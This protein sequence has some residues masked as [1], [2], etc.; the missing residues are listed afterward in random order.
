MRGRK[1][2]A[3]LSLPFFVAVRVDQEFHGCCDPSVI[4]DIIDIVHSDWGTVFD[5]AVI[6]N[7]KLTNENL[8]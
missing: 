7:E 5:V 3:E 2:G 6:R 8:S 4:L 1:K